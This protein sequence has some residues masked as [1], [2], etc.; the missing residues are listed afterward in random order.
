VPWD[1]KKRSA[2]VD[3]YKGRLKELQREKCR[4]DIK[5][6]LHGYLAEEGVKPV[7]PQLDVWQELYDPGNL[8]HGRRK[9]ICIP[10]GRGV[11]KSFFLRLITYVLVAIFDGQKVTPESPQTGI[12]ILWFM[13]TFKHWVDVHADLM[14]QE[15]EGPW[16]FLGVRRGRDE[17][18]DGTTYK[19]RFPGGSTIKPFPALEHTAKT[20]RGQRADVVLIDECDDVPEHIFWSVIGP[21]HSEPWSYKLQVVGG[22][23]RLGKHGLLYHLH[24][25]GLSDEPADRSYFSFHATYR[26]APEVVDAE[27]VA[28][29]KARMPAPIFA[30]EWECKFENPEGL[31]YDGWDPDFHVQDLPFGM[32][33]WRMVYVGV[34]HGYVNPGCF[35]LG[36][37][38]GKED[39][40]GEDTRRLWIV[41]EIYETGK[42]TDWWAERA[43]EWKEREHVT[44]SKG[45]NAVIPGIRQVANLLNVYG[46]KDDGG[47]TRWA[48]LYVSPRCVNL[49][50][51]MG[52]YRWAKDP[53]DPDRYI[54]EVAPRQSDHACDSLRYLVAGIF[55]LAS[56]RRHVVQGTSYG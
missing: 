20:A 14:V 12:R 43:V 15:L 32:A 56:P 55:G 2:K 48:R 26:D 22:T 39:D 50:R 11:G 37:L 28:E 36:V 23:P 29:Q 42:I 18:I 9:T 45:L 10:W 53:R 30:R 19:V 34:D 4:R 44:S 24:E 47:D 49:I 5:T 54:E 51:E 3:F 35:L 6:D 21:I 8:E 13:D 40:N 16:S 33:H 1:P 17:G 31:V 7:K 27:T 41:D 46:S 25:A 52:T 38:T